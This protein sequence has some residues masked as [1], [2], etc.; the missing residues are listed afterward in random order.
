MHAIRVKVGK[1]ITK[2]FGLRMDWCYLVAKPRVRKS[3]AKEKRQR[4]KNRA[5]KQLELLLFH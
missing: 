3:T 1:E 4:T 5:E 2:R